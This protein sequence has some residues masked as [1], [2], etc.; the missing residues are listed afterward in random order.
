MVVF[1]SRLWSAKWSL[2]RRK[3]VHLHH[4][5]Q[6]EK[7]SIAQAIGI[8]SDQTVIT[9]SNST[10]IIYCALF[11]N[12]VHPALFPRKP[13]VL[14]HPVKWSYHL[15]SSVWMYIVLSKYLLVL[16]RCRKCVQCKRDDSRI[17]FSLGSKTN[18]EAAGQFAQLWRISTG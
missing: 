6:N 18:L 16:N 14:G 2:W 13:S 17:H 8:I 10:Y 1:Q 4:I 9:F 12:C 7:L 11:R 15:S 3:Q 5:N